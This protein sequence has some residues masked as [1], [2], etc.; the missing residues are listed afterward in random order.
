M[1]VNLFAAKHRGLEMKD[2]VE[3]D[4]EPPDPE[5]WKSELVYLVETRQYKHFL[6]SE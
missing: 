3:T 6:K 1:R 4:I 5:T 2:G